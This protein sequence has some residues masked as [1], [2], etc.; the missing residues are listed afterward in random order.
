MPAYRKPAPYRKPQT[1]RGSE[2]VNPVGAPTLFGATATPWR[3]AEDH[4]AQITTPWLQAPL[5]SSPVSTPWQR[6]D[7]LSRALA[8]AWRQAAANNADVSLPWSK[9]APFSRDIRQPWIQPT[10]HATQAAL[11]WEQFAQQLAKAIGAPWRTPEVHSFETTLRWGKLLAQSAATSLLWQRL[12]ALGAHVALP[13][14]TGSNYQTGYRNPYVN[15]PDDGSALVFPDL[16]VYIM[17]PTIS[18][19]VIPGGAD[20]AP[21]AVT[22]NGDVD[23]WCWSFEMQIPPETFPLVNPAANPDPVPI[24][25]TVNGFAWS[26]IVESYSDNRKFGARGYTIRGRSQSAM[27]AEDYAPT[28]TLLETGDYNAA[29]LADH[30]VA[31]TGWTMIWDALDWLVPG[32]TFTYADLAPIAAIQAIA[33][34]IGATLETEPDALNIHAKPRYPIPP[35]QWDTA[36]PYAIV[37]A[38]IPT[39]ASGDWQ[40]GNNA[41]GIYVYPQNST[42]GAFVRITG[43]GGVNPMKMV[44]DPLVVTNPAQAARGIQELAKAGR[45]KH[46]V[47]IFP[48]FPA[49]A[50]PSLMPLRKLLELTD[51]DGT[52]WRGQVMANSITATRGGGAASVR[53]AL[54]IERQFR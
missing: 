53:Q 33:A 20:L 48:L 47:R 42:S 22:I 45:S 19:V 31:S 52:V 2:V 26:F 21:L 50:S 38:A 5:Q 9:L 10:P 7:S 15:P 12:A 25:V 44:V 39:S 51:E 36:T 54:T 30:E 35:W 1:Y 16:P 13:W 29:Q 18:A 14:G 27:L 43:T 46:E 17:I 11:P 34:S 6:A 37:P 32:G 40:G 24:R 28:R 8:H 23:S 3:D 41:N 4:A 49:P